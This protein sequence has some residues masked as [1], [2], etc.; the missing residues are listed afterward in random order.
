MGDSRPITATL[1]D[2]VSGVAD[3]GTSPFLLLDVVDFQ[4]GIWS[5]RNRR[6]CAL[7]AYQHYLRRHGSSQQVKVR[8]CVLP[9]SSA[10]VF[11][12]FGE[13]LSTENDGYSVEIR[14]SMRS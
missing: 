7:K 13:C 9:L 1:T 14:R 8:A 10:A 12:K 2:L 6:L 3:P 4:G 5:L 11:V